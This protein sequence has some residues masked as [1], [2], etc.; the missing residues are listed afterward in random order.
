M[1]SL[2]GR[3]PRSRLLSRSRLGGQ[4]R[5]DEQRCSSFTLAAG[6]DPIGTASPFGAYLFVEVPPPWPPSVW[7]AG[8]LP[9]GLND[10]RERAAECHPDLRWLAIAPDPEHSRPGF[11]RVL[12]FRRPPAPFATYQRREFLIPLEYVTTL[13]EAL[14]EGSPDGVGDFERFEQA[15]AG[16]R[17]LLVCTHGS[18]DACC[19][20]FGVPLYTTLRQRHAA[21]SAGALRAW[22]V[23]HIGGH[24]FAPT[25]L[26][27]PEGRCWA[28]LDTETLDVVVRRDAHPAPLRHKY[29]GWSGLDFFGQVVEREAF[30]RHGWVWTSYPK[31]GQILAVDGSYDEADPEADPVFGDRPPRAV[32]VRLTYVSPDSGVAG[33]YEATVEWSGRRVGRGECGATCWERNTYRISRLRKVPSAGP[34]RATTSPGSEEGRSS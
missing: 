23:S 20:T 31:A 8:R 29:R 2:A 5:H 3:T 16:V 25:M 26:D 10:L 30:L 11:A 4:L 17:D 33:A 12:H 19:G 18:E 15:T 21:R 34:D 22:R 1:T 32:D 6:E 27:F 7:Q 13:L 14:L 24:R 28:H 9:P